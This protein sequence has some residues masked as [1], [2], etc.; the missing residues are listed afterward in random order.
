MSAFDPKQTF[1]FEFLDRQ[2]DL[3]YLDR[4]E[5][6]FRVQAALD[7]GGLAEAVLLARKQQIPNWFALAA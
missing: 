1:G 4:V 3:E 6:E 7:G 2:A 5:V